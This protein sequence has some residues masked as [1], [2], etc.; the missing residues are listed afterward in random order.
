M[1]ESCDFHG[2]VCRRRV[3]FSIS[4]EHPRQSAR[5]V[6]PVKAFQILRH[7]AFVIKVIK[8][9]SGV[10]YIVPYLIV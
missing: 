2:S 9:F 6:P 10:K 5:I 3:N 8:S 1:I 4:V 7:L